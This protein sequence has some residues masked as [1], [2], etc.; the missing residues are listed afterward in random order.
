MDEDQA[1]AD[2]ALEVWL[3]IV[4]AAKHWLSLSKSKR[5]KNNKSN[6]TL[7]KHHQ[8]LLIPAKFY[9]FHRRNKTYFVVFQ[10][11]IPLLPFMFDE[12]SLVLYRLVRLVS[13]K[14]KLTI[15][16]ISEK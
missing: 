14:R 9:F 16:S 11:D 6:E 4:S 1:V 7:V 8:D 12:I 3:F 2:R 10:S 15:L 13:S 5:P